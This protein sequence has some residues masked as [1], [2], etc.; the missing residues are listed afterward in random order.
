[1]LLKVVFIGM[2]VVVFVALLILWPT[3]L[4]VNLNEPLSEYRSQSGPHQVAFRLLR[5][6]STGDNGLVQIQV[7][8]N[9]KAV[10]TLPASYSYDTLIS[11]PAGRFRWLWLDGDL[12]P[13]VQLE[14]NGFGGNQAFYIGSRDGG[15][16]ARSAP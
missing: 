8:V 10:K 15:F 6:T 14:P 9:G 1:M 2:G 7:L 5:E 11:Q 12:W 3:S 4:D 13:D 16:Y